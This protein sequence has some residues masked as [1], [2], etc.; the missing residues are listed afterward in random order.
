MDDDVAAA[1]VQL[2]KSR[3][4][5]LKNIV[6]ETLRAGLSEMA[7]PKGKSKPFRTRTFDMGELLVDVTCVSQALAIAEGEDYK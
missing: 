3:N 2:R 4:T 7:R 6:N 1:L 5:S